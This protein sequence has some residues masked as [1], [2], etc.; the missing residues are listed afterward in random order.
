MRTKIGLIIVILTII[1]LSSP[2]AQSQTEIEKPVQKSVTETYPWAWSIFLATG[3]GYPQG[4]RSE[5]GFNFSNFLSAGLT[6]NIIDYWSRDPKEGMIGLMGRIL[7]PQDNFP[8]LTPYILVAGGG[9]ISI[10]GGSDSYIEVY[11]GI[12]YQIEKYLQFRGEAGLDWTSRYVSGGGLFNSSP[13]VTND[14]YRIGI[15]AALEL[16]IF[17]IFREL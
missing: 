10:F 7:L 2:N 9:T 5:L 17:E 3:Y 1:N 15:H 4:S 16:A 14:I 11:I 8:E 6:F 12:M 13:I